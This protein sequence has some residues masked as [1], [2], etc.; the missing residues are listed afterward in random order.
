MTIPSVAQDVARNA[1]ISLS[2]MYLSFVDQYGAALVTSL[3]ICFGILQIVLRWRE[4]RAIM[5]KNEEARDEREGTG[6]R[7]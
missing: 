4:H 7:I 6:D 1:P 2:A 3:A 5:K